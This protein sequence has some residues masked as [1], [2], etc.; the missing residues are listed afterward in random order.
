MMDNMLSHHVKGVREIL[1]ELKVLY[2]PPY[3]PDFNPNKKMWPTVKP[4]LRCRADARQ[5]GR[6]SYVPP[7]SAELLSVFLKIAIV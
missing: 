2:L 1:E 7:V 4:I 3:S 5:G 6:R